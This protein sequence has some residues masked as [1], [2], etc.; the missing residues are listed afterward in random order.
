MS[1][2]RSY[3]LFILLCVLALKAP[4]QKYSFINYG[5]DKGLSQSQAR[6]IAQNRN[7]ELLIG[8]LGG[9]S[10]FDGTTF[11]NL[12]KSNG[13]PENAV[14]TIVCDLQGTIWVGTNNGIARFDGTKSQTYM[15]VRQGDNHVR[16]LAMD[17]EGRIWALLDN[18]VLYSWNGDQFSPEP[19]VDSIS[20]ITIDKSGKLWAYSYSRGLMVRDNR[21]G[22]HEEAKAPGPQK[23]RVYKLTI[24]HY[25]GSLYCLSDQGMLSPESK[26]LI[27]AGFDL[28]VNSLPNAILEDSKGT[29]WLS[30][31]DGGAWAYRKKTWSHYTYANGLTDDIIEDFFEDVEGNVWL[32]SNGSG[33]YRFSGSVFT[34]YD[35][36][37][38]LDAPS[39]MS[40]AQTKDGTLYFASGKLG[41]FSLKQKQIHKISLP[42]RASGIHSI[43]SDSTTG[44]LWLGTRSEGLWNY[45]GG[46]A[47]PIAQNAALSGLSINHLSRY[48]NTIWIATSKGL[49]RYKDGLL[50]REPIAPTF[51]YATWALNE[52]SLLIGTPKGAFLY[53][54]DVQSL[55]PRPLLARTTT[56]CFAAKGDKVFMGTDDKGVIIWDQKTGQLTAINQ[57]SGL[58]CNYIYNLTK[59]RH[60]DLWIGTGCGIDKLGQAQGKWKIKSFGSADGLLG[61]E[62]NANASFEDREGFLWF[63]TTKGLYRYDPYQEPNGQRAPIVAIQSVKL[64]SK[65]LPLAYSDGA[66]GPDHL[67]LDPILPT[68]Q[69]HISFTFK[70][71]SLSNPES[72]KYRYQLV[73]ADKGFTETNQRAVIYPNL[74]PGNYL[75]KVRASDAD[76]N[77]YDNEATYPFRIQKPYYGTWPF[78]IMVLAGALLAAL[79]IILYRTRQRKRKMLWEEKLRQE[80]QYLVRR[81]TAEDFHDEVG[82]KLTRISLLA[83]IAESKLPPTSGPKELS[84]ILK[85]IKLNTDS[86]YQGAKDII[87]SLQPESDYLDEVVFRIE[88]NIQE[89]I[90]HGN[91]RFV[92]KGADR[93]LADIKL[94]IDYSRNLILIFKEAVGN[95]IKHAR[96]T[97]ITFETTLS[98][99]DLSFELSDN[100]KGFQTEAPTKGNGLIN[101][102]N[103]AKRIGAHLEIATSP[104]RGTKM[105][106]SLPLKKYS[107]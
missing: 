83:T 12:S 30:F 38:G 82:N 98:P 2:G 73:G 4:A 99:S 63:G 90:E 19:S 91:V 8:T 20:A 31:N 97:E 77:W 104:G 74:P 46:S 102:S 35:R 96:A 23:P 7:N 29:L 101:M 1:R 75:F 50:S 15:P 28:P 6:A 43:V 53:R 89:A 55:S 66:T 60:D 26:K 27:R 37:S 78:R 40:I 103:R 79:L 106:L 52:D 25:S 57:E 80:E 76:G 47:R 39:I 62:N 3:I 16:Q 18:F 59:D 21:D 58:S 54:T 48:K 95:I 100:G 51:L 93:G 24:G 61:A 14:N 13:L 107:T 45:T 9:L 65:D 87:W 85:Q 69:N 105:R 33:I 92:S 34:Y 71:I 49:Y 22:W 36:S 68:H 32:A 5:I 67:P 64:F 94:P 81:K 84:E 70:G 72:I 11:S 41:L 10:I 17:G 56:L 86:L 42:F 44:H 88:Q